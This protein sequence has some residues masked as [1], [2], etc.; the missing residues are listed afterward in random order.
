M[1]PPR[2]LNCSPECSVTAQEVRRPPMRV[3]LLDRR[4]AESP[5]SS[6]AA[7]AAAQITPF[8][9][10]DMPILRANSVQLSR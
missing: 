1:P 2:L 4:A 6:A 9:G 10:P 3:L 5:N 7:A 8:A